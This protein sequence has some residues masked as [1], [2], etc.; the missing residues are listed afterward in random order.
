VADIQVG[1][2]ASVKDKEM[3]QRMRLRFEITEL[4]EKNLKTIAGINV[5]YTEVTSAPMSA[6]M[7]MGDLLKAGMG[8]GVAVLASVYENKP[9]FIATATADIVSKG[10]HCGKLIKKISAIAGG[11]GGGKADMAQAGA[12]DSDKIGQAMDAVPAAIEE[13]LKAGHA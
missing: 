5:V 1:L 11:S 8:S 2:K 4:L 3:Q 13:L 10:V 9:F 7:E 6:L 12:K